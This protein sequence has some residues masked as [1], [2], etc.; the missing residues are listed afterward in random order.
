MDRLIRGTGQNHQIRVIGAI[1]TDLVNEAV[2]N[3]K[4]SPV[5]SA[6]LGRLLTGTLMMGVTMKND[7]DKLTIQ[8]KGDGPIGGLLVTANSTGQAKG[9]AVNPLVDIPPKANGKLDVSGAVGKGMLQVIKDIG[10][11]EAYTG[12]IQLVS[13]E[14]AEDLT[15]YYFHSEQ[16]PSIVALGVLVDKDYTIKQSGGVMI[17]LLP[18]A[19][20]HVIATLEK[21]MV[22]IPSI[23]EL[24]EEGLSLEAIIERFLEGLSF[25]KM[26]EIEPSFLCDCNKERFEQGIVG[27]G[28]KDIDEIIAEGESIETTCHF[29]NKHYTFT[30]EELEAIRTRIG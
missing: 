27:L 26:D 6:A 12:Q 20:E 3:H 10:L 22:D 16:T 8:V 17:Q 29:C 2:N 30:I 25:Q 28:L 14:I 15:H 18:N 24:M 9:Y 11:K 19:K 23:T 13:G 21:N 1:T 7:K 5:A 4:S